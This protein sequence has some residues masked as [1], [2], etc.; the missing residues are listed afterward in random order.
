MQSFIPTRGL[1]TVA[2]NAIVQTRKGESPRMVAVLFKNFK[3]EWESTTPCKAGTYLTELE[4]GFEGSVEC[5]YLMIIESNISSTP[6]FGF[7]ANIG[8][9]ERTR[10]V[11]ATWNWLSS[12]ILSVIFQVI[13]VKT[14]NKGSA[15]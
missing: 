14:K 4:D 6:P 2:S 12:S 15:T 5:R 7:P 10:E 13:R 1:H 9:T 11:V 3:L 8:G